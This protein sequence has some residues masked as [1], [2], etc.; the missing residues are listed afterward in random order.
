R[1][2]STRRRPGPARSGSGGR[3]GADA[4]ARPRPQSRIRASPMV[5]NTN[6]T[7]TTIVMRSRFFSITVEPPAAAPTPPPNMSDRPP[8][9]PEWSRTSPMRARAWLTWMVVTMIFSIGPNGVG[10]RN[11]RAYQRRP[12]GHDPPAA[13]QENCQFPEGRSAVGAVED[14]EGA[15]GAGAEGGS[16]GDGDALGVDQPADVALVQGQPGQRRGGQVAQLLGG[17]LALTLARGA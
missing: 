16:F 11:E 4:P 13:R 14:V 12:G 1:P 3:A 10:D 5:V 8:P 17:R 15:E 6:P 7:A 2:R 9:L